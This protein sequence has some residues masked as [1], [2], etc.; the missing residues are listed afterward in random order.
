MATKNL[1]QVA[2][3]WIGTS[4]PS[5]TSLIWF[6]STPA[7]RAHKVYSARLGAWTV[8]DQNTISA[9]AYSD[10]RNLANSTGLTQGSW[11]KITD[12]SNALALAVTT[13]KIQYN[14]NNNNLII[15]DLAASST[16]VVNSNNLL[17]DDTLGV[18]DSSTN[19]LKFT[20][21]DINTVTTNISNTLL[22]YGKHASTFIKVRVYRLISSV[23][24]NSITWNNGFFFNF[25]SNLRGQYDVEGGVTSKSK[26][27]TD[28]AALQQNID[29]V[30]ASNQQILTSAKNYTDGEVVNTKIYGKAIP[31]SPTSGTA[32]DIIA[33]DT[34]TTIINKI[35][36]WINQFKTAEGIKLSKN[37]VPASSVQ[38]VNN[39]D[40]VD[41]AFRKVQ[42]SIDDIN[43]NISGEFAKVGTTDVET[44]TTNPSPITKT[45]TIKQAIQKLVYWVTHITNDKIEALTIQE[46]RLAV[47]VLPT[48][49][50]RVDIQSNVDLS[51]CGFGA[52]FVAGDNGFFEPKTDYPNNPYRISSYYDSGDWDYPILGFS[53]VTQ[54]IANNEN[55]YSVATKIPH[56]EGHLTTGSSWD[57]EPDYSYLVGAYL[58]VM[59]HLSQSKYDSIYNSGKR[60]LKISITSVDVYGAQRMPTTTVYYYSLQRVNIWGLKFLVSDFAS[61][62]TKH[63]VV[64]WN[65]EFTT[66]NTD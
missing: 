62:S 54:V 51:G 30:A 33:G 36:R 21:N 1:G 22:L 66:T 35:H 37:F 17:I 2:G 64:G 41:S 40:T 7:I 53:P 42:K 13:T 55:Q 20:F 11:Y 56:Y 44:L 65:I 5:N 43:E 52:V 10:L 15:D 23:A 4:A 34:L 12:K 59:I 49:I 19:K 47:G 45:D 58:Q 57:G 61:T 3:L 31:T 39:N 27:D 38:S 60:Y 16:Y 25:L 8:L 32:T 14:D 29:N 18:W 63:I 48:D 50:L 28:K 9:I 46:S 6:D 24:G 26:H